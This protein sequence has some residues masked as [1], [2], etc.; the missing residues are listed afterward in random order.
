MARNVHARTVSLPLDLEAEIERRAA[1]AGKS[2][3]ATVADMC[4]RSVHMDFDRDY[5]PHISQVV[6]DGNDD[7]VRRVRGAV[8]VAMEDATGFMLEEVRKMIEEA[9]DG[10]G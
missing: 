5:V 1:M 4:R 3:S 6:R 8:D 7:V 9:A 2:F 10:R